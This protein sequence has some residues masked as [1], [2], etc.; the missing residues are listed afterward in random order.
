MLIRIW[1]Y[2][3][4]LY[5]SYLFLCTKSSYIN[6]YRWFSYKDSA[7]E[8][9]LDTCQEDKDECKDEAWF[10]DRISRI[11]KTDYPIKGNLK[12]AFIDAWSQKGNRNKKDSSQ[13][14]HW[15]KW[16]DT[17]WN[18]AT[19]EGEV[20]FQTIND[21]LA[22]NHELN[23]NLETSKTSNVQCNEKLNGSNYQISGN[24]IMKWCSLISLKLIYGFT[25]TYL[26]YYYRI[27]LYITLL[28]LK[29]SQQE[30]AENLNLCL[31]KLNIT[32][33][34]VVGKC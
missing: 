26:K 9:R 34:H 16:T 5:F 18:F 8:E 28:G 1:Y 30:I 29:E 25:N 24:L 32:T 33:T 13:Q 31:N 14:Q 17:L 23:Q 21:V 7:V 2:I 11:L 6:I 22:K 3:Q 10:I 15:K 19:S 20:V 27:D 4:Q 12:F